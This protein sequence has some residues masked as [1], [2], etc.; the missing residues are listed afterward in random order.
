M[1]FLRAKQKLVIG[2]LLVV[3]ANVLV[4]YLLIGDRIHDAQTYVD[5]SIMRTSAQAPDPRIIVV[6][7][8]DQSLKD[9]GGLGNWDRAI[10]G[11]LIAFLKNAGARVVAFDVLFDLPTPRD[12]LFAQAI[13][14]AQ[15]SSGGTSPMP[16]I[17]AADGDGDR[18]RIPGQGLAYD[19]FLVPSPAIMAGQPQ[20]ANVTVDPD[21]AVVRHLPLRAVAGSQHYYLLPFVAVNA[22]QR[23]PSLDQEAKLRPD[24]VFAGNRLIPTDSDF[25]M[26]INYEGAPFAF[27]KLSLSKVVAGDYPAS[28]FKDK[29][30]FVGMMGATGLADDYPV[31]TSQT[32]K[33]WGVE[34]WANGAQNILD[35]KFV[36]QQ[37]QITTLLF[38]VGLSAV[39]AL[40]FFLW[41]AAG[42]FLTFGILIAYS[43]GE[44]LFTVRNLSTP[45]TAAQVIVL[46]NI[47][48][49]G[50]NVLLS[51][52]ALFI[53]FFIVE[54]RSRRAIGRMFGKYLTPEV[55]KLVMDQQ[56]R[57][58]LGLGGSV[59]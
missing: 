3:L 34:I 49:V 51:S 43:V 2:I 25:R 46:P 40:G 20:L 7:I 38:M 8:D 18:G 21:G 4:A 33:M 30:V 28:T 17:L 56:E 24:G 35:G 12:P 10:Y 44:Y 29:L 55:A 37:E 54:Q 32:T 13:A 6:A 31:P 41:G 19:Q 1:N 11:K 45:P 52:A 47:A 59:K 26:L 14:Y 27:P 50:A 39:A 16:V 36:V 53:W 48:Y 42:W 22:Y 5:D 15:S 23:R 58:E 9:Y 57:G